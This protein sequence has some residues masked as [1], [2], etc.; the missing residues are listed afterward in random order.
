[1]IAAIETRRKTTVKGGNSRST[2]PL[3]KNDPPHSTESNASSDQ[4]RESIR[5]SLAVIAAHICA[6][7]QTLTA[8]AA[9]LAT[10]FPRGHCACERDTRLYWSLKPQ[11][12]CKHSPTVGDVPHF[13]PSGAPPLGQN[14]ETRVSLASQLAA[15]SA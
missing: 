7:E 2:T 4:S 5:S 14:T 12:L 6:N 9:T 8:K 1:M 10:R 13:A 11:G 15:P 3:K